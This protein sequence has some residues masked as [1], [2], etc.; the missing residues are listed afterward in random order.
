MTNRELER[1]LAIALEHAAPDD[2]EGVLSRCEQRK[3]TVIP[4]T[5]KR[6]A[7]SPGRLIAACLA[8][9]LIF[10]FALNW[11]Q[12]RA[13]TSVIS[14]DV[15]PSIELEIN[16]SETVISCR[17]L[18]PDAEQV[19]ADMNGGA[20][21]EGAKLSVAV[22]AV[23]GALVRSGY[24]NSLSSAILI[25][26]EDKDQ[27]RATRLRQE[28]AAV[29]DTVLRDIS[30]D[31]AVLSQTIAKNQELAQQARENSVSTGK[32]YLIRQIMEKNGSLTFDALAALT[33][34]ELR[35]LLE[36]GAP[37]MPIGADRAV[38]LVLERAGLTA[39]QILRFEVDPD[40]ADQLG[41]YEVELL[42]ASGQ[43]HYLVDA[44]TGTVY[45][46]TV[47]ADVLISAEAAL[48]AALEYAGLTA[49][50]VLR[51]EVDEELDDIPAHYEVELFLSGG[52]RRFRVDALTGTVSGNTGYDISP[53]DPPSPAPSGPIS[54][55]QSIDIALAHAGLYRE[56]VSELKAELDE[57]EFEVEFIY[58]GYEYEYSIH[59]STG[60]ILEHEKSHHH[61]D[62]YED[63]HH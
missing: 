62:H 51:W 37:D 16:R 58:G 29:V 41:G 24:L 10:G 34:G 54:G 43:Y 25:S 31:A 17:P 45:G 35:E 63:R 21:L 11:Q 61:D 36:A 47:Y 27:T 13:V 2:P 59:C 20:D 28:L 33:V 49:E 55:E 5:N 60:S 44:Y 7:F 18:N 56:K 3:G 32:A 6:K 53:T 12:T 15:N 4:M 46:G 30:S 26:V 48:N 14:L 23:T 1:K 39:D 9:A 22:N 52:E 50:E 38:E 57:L 8:L 19:L 40:L 42:T